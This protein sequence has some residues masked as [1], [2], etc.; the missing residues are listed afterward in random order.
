M[1]SQ[2]D[3]CASTPEALL[4][5]DDSFTVVSESVEPSSHESEGVQE[6][7]PVSVAVGSSA[8]EA[9]LRLNFFP[10]TEIGTWGRGS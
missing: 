1:S 2:A 4:P 8:D 9:A 3:S 7:E 10:Y 5:I 6:A